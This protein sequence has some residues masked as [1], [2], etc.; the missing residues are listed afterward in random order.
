MWLWGENHKFSYFF[1]AEIFLPEPLYSQ[2]LYPVD[3]FTNSLKAVF[4]DPDPYGTLKF[5]V[6]KLFVHCPLLT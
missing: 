1:S 2:R 4:L 5:E 3:H 6:S